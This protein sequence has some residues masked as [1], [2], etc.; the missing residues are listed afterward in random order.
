MRKVQK[1]ELVLPFPALPL[2]HGAKHS[3][4][5]TS[6]YVLHAGWQW[7]LRSTQKSVPFSFRPRAPQQLK[8]LNTLLRLFHLGKTVGGEAKPTVTVFKL[9]NRLCQCKPGLA[10]SLTLLISSKLPLSV[11]HCFFNIHAFPS[12]TWLSWHSRP[13]C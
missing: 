12:L 2:A 5:G 11:K 6:S 3:S 9:H 1:E 10:S 13:N 4:H 7:G 8:V